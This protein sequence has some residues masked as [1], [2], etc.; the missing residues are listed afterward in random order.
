MRRSNAR[1]GRWWEGE[2][3]AIET[4]DAESAAR[5]A[6]WLRLRLLEGVEIDTFLARVGRD[7]AWLEARTARSRGRGNVQVEGGWMRVAPG[8]WMHH[9]D[10]AAEVL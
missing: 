7:R 3:A 1:G 6:L 4:L 5:E 2:S 8:R 10:I 9:D